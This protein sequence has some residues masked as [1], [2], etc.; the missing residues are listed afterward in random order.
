MFWAGMPQQRG[1]ALS[2][3]SYQAAQMSLHAV[4]G[5]VTFDHLIKLLSSRLS[6]VKLL[7]FPVSR[8]RVLWGGILKLYAHLILYQHS[9]D[10][11]IIFIYTSADSWFPVRWH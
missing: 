10:S 1:R 9:I 11:S 8:I 5:G 7:F 2:I 6:T 4:T 3:A